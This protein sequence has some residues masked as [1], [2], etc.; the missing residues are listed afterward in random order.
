MGNDGEKSAPRR[1]NQFDN[2]EWEDASTTSSSCHVYMVI[3]YLLLLKDVSPVGIMTSWQASLEKTLSTGKE[4]VCFQF[5]GSLIGATGF[6]KACQS[7]PGN[8]CSADSRWD[9]PAGLT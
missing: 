8:S 4:R 6:F 1:Q 2:F 5:L 3:K 7:I 9:A